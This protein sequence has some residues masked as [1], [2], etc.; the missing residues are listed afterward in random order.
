MAGALSRWI[1]RGLAGVE[2][3]GNRLPDPIT[4]FVLFMAIV[5]LASW[6][7]AGIGLSATHPGTGEEIRALNL[8]TAD[9]LR[10]VNL[11]QVGRIKLLDE[12][13]DAETRCYEDADDLDQRDDGL[14]ASNLRS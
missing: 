10:A 1:D 11:E 3:V 5:L 13:L 7:A 8:L 2:R 14:Q 9:G 6:I 4:L 12:K